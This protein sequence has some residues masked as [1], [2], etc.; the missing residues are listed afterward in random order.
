MT[1]KRKLTTYGIL[2][3]AGLLAAGAAARPHLVASP[4]A[5]VVVAAVKPPRP[6]APTKIQVALLLDT[7]GS[8]DGLLDQA[9]S[10]LW[11]IVNELAAARKR[12]LAASLEIALY[13][14]G[15]STVSAEDGYVRRILPFTTDLDRV[16]EEL[17]ALHTNGGDEYCG[18][19]I[20]S[21]T[22]DLEWSASHDDL[23]LVFIAGNEAFTQ[24]P[25]DFRKA[26]G[27]AKEKGITVNVIHCGG[28]DPTWR[29][30]ARV[31]S[32]EYV[33]I[34][35]NARVVA[36]AAP[37]DDELHRLGAELN[38]TYL[39]YG[40]GGRL[41]L[42]RQEAQDKNAAE[43]AQGAS[44]QR[45]LAKASASYSNAA[46]D[47]V[48]GVRDGVISLE[49]TEQLPEE[50]RAMT[51]EQRKAH[52]AAAAT[53]RAELRAR[54]QALNVERERFVAAELAR[55]GE[56]AGATLDKAVV[57]AVRKQAE[58]RGFSFAK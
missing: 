52:V 37:Q 41:A 11:R 27:G 36:I 19:A 25:V 43:A 33:M 44:T 8:M 13:E 30:G 24:G 10:Q 9:R 16:S 14:Y 31:A 21:A 18:K 3:F 23:K 40:A 22:R 15:K 38:R 2:G 55:A 42:A 53:K 39:G 7:S 48:D 1:R 56:D 4:P 50:M 35:H 49:A 26:I 28:D 45:T 34:D 32:G 12:G 51:L 57:A 29:E 46:W 17:F 47:L 54:I 58:G 6:A 20:E 5:P